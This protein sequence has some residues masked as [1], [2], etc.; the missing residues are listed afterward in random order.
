MFRILELTT[1]CESITD[2]DIHCTVHCCFNFNT[3]RTDLTFDPKVHRNQCTMYSGSLKH[4]RNLQ[5]IR[6]KNI[7]FH[8]NAYVLPPFLTTPFILHPGAKERTRWPI[9]GGWNCKLQLC[10]IFFIIIFSPSFKISWWRNVTC[11]FLPP[12]QKKLLNTRTFAFNSD[13]KKIH[14]A[15]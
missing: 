9:A 4:F 6:K 2:Y 12:P 15:F 10:S 14:R 11:C 7:A 13:I 5:C 1:N 8:S 3:Q